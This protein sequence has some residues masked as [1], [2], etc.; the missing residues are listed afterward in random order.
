MRHE[1]QSKVKQPGDKG[2]RVLT[3][4]LV[5]YVHARSAFVMNLA[6]EARLSS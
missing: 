4:V 3:S 1:I 2:E 5:L 6:R